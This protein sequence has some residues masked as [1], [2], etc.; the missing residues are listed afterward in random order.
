MSQ[1]QPIDQRWVAM[2]ARHEDEVGA[3]VRK[4]ATAQEQFSS[5]VEAAHAAIL[6]RHSQQ[7]KEFYGVTPNTPSHALSTRQSVVAKTQP[8]TSK[9]GF[10]AAHTTQKP[11]PTPISSDK[12][13]SGG[14]L[15]PLSSTAHDSQREKDRGTP[16]ASVS[17]QQAEKQLKLSYQSL[18]AQSHRGE[19]T[20][21]V[22]T[23]DQPLMPRQRKPSG[24]GLRRRPA[25]V[26]QC[27]II[28]LCSDDD[29]ESD[30]D[31]VV[32]VTRST[33][34][35]N[36]A[37]PT[38]VLPS[39]PTATLQLFGEK[40]K[41]QPATSEPPLMKRE[42]AEVKRSTQGQPRLPQLAQ[43][44]NQNP[45]TDLLSAQPPHSERYRDSAALNAL[46]SSMSQRAIPPQHRAQAAPQPARNNAPPTFEKDTVY[47]TNTAIQDTSDL[48]VNHTALPANKE[49]PPL[50]QHKQNT[51]FVSHTLDNGRMEVTI[52]DSIGVF[53][54][55]SSDDDVDIE[56]VP[57]AL[58]NV[59]AVLKQLG[60]I[61]SNNDGMELDS[62]APTVGKSSNYMSD[63]QRTHLPTPSPSFASTPATC[64]VSEA[65]ALL[66]KFKKP[67]LPVTTSGEN[68]CSQIC[69]ANSESSRHTT[70][71]N[72]LPDKPL[73]SRRESSRASHISN[74]STLSRKRRV[75][76]LS[77]DEQ[78]MY[79]PSE[80]STSTERNMSASFLSFASKKSRLTT[81]KTPEP[82]DPLPPSASFVDPMGNK[83]NGMV[84]KTVAQSIPM[85]P[86]RTPVA[87]SKPSTTRTPTQASREKREVFTISPGKRHA[88]M[89]AQ[90]MIQKFSEA[91]EEF[92]TEDQ[93]FQAAARKVRMGGAATADLGQRLRSMSITPVPMST[94][95]N[96]RKNSTLPDSP[97]TSANTAAR[98]KTSHG[99][100]T[101]NRPSTNR[102]INGHLGLRSRNINQLIGDDSDKDSEEDLDISEFT[103]VN[104]II[105]QAGQEGRLTEVQT[106][107]I[108]VKD[109]RR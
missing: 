77:D 84:F 97:T 60:I 2:R 10:A 80:S 105:I 9:M 56:D 8:T 52:P 91:D 88:A 103:Y 16:S 94:P 19:R 83:R 106:K 32:E 43:N 54:R 95:S 104:G 55:S 59:K 25:Q 109:G 23:R 78:S 29:D 17:Q 44:N 34:H 98:A 13:Q 75:V 46:S 76:D 67:P 107:P 45:V 1:P 65:A 38:P 20:A 70:T 18:Q 72:L 15:T 42:N 81:S 71:A 7:E 49:L 74:I 57:L 31:V 4:I 26:K 68:D 64:Q 21:A 50:H 82:K 3:F 101:K 6:A 24:T 63:M 30:D 48:M 108:I 61:V 39:I 36:T 86:S 79:S 87:N 93:I 73:V 47:P 90:Q 53:T 28:N 40:P 62:S 51:G 11:L 58:L 99:I 33:Y 92:H 35:E 12:R 14:Q 27:E 69:T 66:S 22:P 89:K 37:V 5:Q 41:K 100:Y 85:A 96:V 102:L